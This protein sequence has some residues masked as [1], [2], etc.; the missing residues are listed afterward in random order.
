MFAFEIAVK[1]GGKSCFS[2]CVTQQTQAAADAALI[3]L[4]ASAH[5]DLHKSMHIQTTF[6]FTGVSSERAE[7]SVMKSLY[8]HVKQLRFCIFLQLQPHI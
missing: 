1:Q 7:W 2:V 4:P 8:A 5:K 6:V 3:R